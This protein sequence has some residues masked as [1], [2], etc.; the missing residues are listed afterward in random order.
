M[1]ILWLAGHHG[2]PAD[3]CG[4]DSATSS[5]ANLIPAI[6]GSAMPIVETYKWWTL[7]LFAT[8]L[9]EVTTAVWNI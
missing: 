6:I 3:T 2:V 1:H 8:L 9:R 5:E 7:G 4:C